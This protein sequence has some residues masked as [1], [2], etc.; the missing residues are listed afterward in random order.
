MGYYQ[1][2][3]PTNCPHDF[4]RR[5]IRLHSSLKCPVILIGKNSFAPFHQA[6]EKTLSNV[7]RGE[8]AQYRKQALPGVHGRDFLP[9]SDVRV[10]STTR[11]PAVPERASTVSEMTLRSSTRIKDPGPCAAARFGRPACAFEFAFKTEHSTLRLPGEKSAEPNACPKWRASYSSN[12]SSTM[13]ATVRRL[14][15]LA[16]RMGQVQALWRFV[17][18]AGFSKGSRKSGCRSQIMAPMA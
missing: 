17:L 3:M 13:L 6:T 15:R 18:K 10:R 2:A 5:M 8:F 1:H 14:H 16:S 11:S 9:S 7:A 4:R 12:A